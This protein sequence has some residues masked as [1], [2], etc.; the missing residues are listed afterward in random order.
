M[1]AHDVIDNGT[2]KIVSYNLAGQVVSTA[3]YTVPKSRDAVSN[4]LTVNGDKKAPN[5]HSYSTHFSTCF[6]GEQTLYKTSTPYGPLYRAQT[7][8]GWFGGERLE[9]RLNLPPQD[10][11]PQWNKAVAKLYDKVRGNLDLSIAVAE[12]H[13][14]KRLLNAM[15]QIEDALKDL[16]RKGE[17]FD[18][19]KPLR[20]LGGRW[21]QWHLAIRPL[22]Q[23]VYGAIDEF[24]RHKV[25][26][27]LEVTAN[28]Y[29]KMPKSM[30]LGKMY[31]SDPV[32]FAKVE[33]V[34]GVKFHLRFKDKGG[35]DLNR[36]T[37]L[38]PASIAWELLPLSFV[39]D[40]FY[41]I[42]QM[43]RSLE[44]A[45]ATE[46]LFVDGY[47]TQLYAV[48]ANAHEVGQ[49]GKSAFSGGDTGSYMYYD[50]KANLNII[51]F[52]RTKLSSMPIPRLPTFKLP[53]S[54]QKLVTMA[55]LLA[56][57]LK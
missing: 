40:Y 1:K 53:T 20:V 13:E 41:N 46:S 11:T 45:L 5:N 14:T 34:Q 42:S 18:W 51:R 19:R 44:S 6:M 37:S 38:N 27:L 29:A 55:S 47:W 3:D 31:P 36:W 16:P 48:S 32:T 26:A 43:L 28:S 52:T 56:V 15:K 33:G 50:A 4:I 49:R 7:T 17:F 57:R 23:D 9:S 21:L 30:P 35:F 54:W 39:F 10:V 8:S 24:Y 12:S 25:P 22:I 2:V